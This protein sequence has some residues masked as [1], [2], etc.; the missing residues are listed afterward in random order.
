[1]PLV[2]GTVLSPVSDTED[3][4]KKIAEP[5]FELGVGDTTEAP[6]GRKMDMLTCG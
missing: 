4:L 3:A 5:N 2:L 6:V 1:M